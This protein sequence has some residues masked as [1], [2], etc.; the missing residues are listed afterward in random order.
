VGDTRIVQMRGRYHTKL[1]QQN[2][3]TQTT[4]LTLTLLSF[5]YSKLYYFGGA[6]S[7]G[8]ATLRNVSKLLFF[9]NITGFQCGPFPSGY[10]GNGIKC[11]G[12]SRMCPV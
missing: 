12:K 6:L 1:A 3:C 11:V 5:C 7:K 4:I 10:S 2:P 9:A 8:F